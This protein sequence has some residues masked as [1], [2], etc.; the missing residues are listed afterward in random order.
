MESCDDV[1]GVISVVLQF[2]VE[3]GLKLAYCYL[4]PLSLLFDNSVVF[5]FL[6]NVSV[7]AL[8]Q[9]LF[10]SLLGSFEVAHTLLQSLQL[11]L[12]QFKRTF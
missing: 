5:S 4:H 10:Q 6:I 7:L 2:K 9:F 8:L 3:V 1:F 11:S 12:F